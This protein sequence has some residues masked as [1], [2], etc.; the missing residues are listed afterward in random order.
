MI[1]YNSIE[2][3]DSVSV[4]GLDTTTN[5]RENCVHKRQPAIGGPF[6]EKYNKIWYIFFSVRLG[7]KEPRNRRRRKRKKKRE[8]FLNEQKER[9]SN[10]SRR[11]SPTVERTRAK[12]SGQE[13]LR[14][15]QV[16]FSV[17]LFSFPNCVYLLP[18]SIANKYEQ[19]H[20]FYRVM[21]SN[22][23][24]SVCAVCTVHGVPCSRYLLFGIFFPLLLSS[25]G[26]LAKAANHNYDRSEKFTMLFAG[27]HHRVTDG[28]F[29]CVYDCGGQGV[30]RTVKV[31]KKFLACASSTRTST[32]AAP[33]V[34]VFVSHL[35]FIRNK[36]QNINNEMWLTAMISVAY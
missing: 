25:S 26:V 31:H 12:E 2:P 33:L 7:T 36:Q 5:K 4:S 13:K 18:M 8:Q 15:V 32:A 11:C 34:F 29:V 9:D 10:I 16:L 14:T 20:V 35:K 19:I 27:A 1:C 21:Q 6:V 28:M 17:T 3:T 23:L 30:L 22:L 24:W